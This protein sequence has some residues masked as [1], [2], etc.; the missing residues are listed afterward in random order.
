MAFMKKD[1]KPIFLHHL[2]SLLPSHRESCVLVVADDV[3]PEGDAEELRRGRDGRRG[4]VR[5]L[6]SAAQVLGAE[7]HAVAWDGQGDG[8]FQVRNC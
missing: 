3:V 5:A 8:V 4:E 1:T 6:V 7:E 2:P